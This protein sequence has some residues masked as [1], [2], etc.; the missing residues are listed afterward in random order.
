MKLLMD[1]P[2]DATA[3]LHFPTVNNKNMATIGACDMGGIGTP[4]HKLFVEIF[5]LKIFIS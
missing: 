3:H 1:V 4:L 5:L 2:L